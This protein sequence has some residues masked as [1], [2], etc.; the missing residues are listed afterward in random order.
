DI[1]RQSVY[2]YREPVFLP[3][4]STIH[5]RYTYDNSSQNVHN[6][7]NPPIRVRAGNRSVD[8]MGHLWMQ[9][10]PV[11]VP[12]NSPDPRLLLETAWMQNRLRKAPHDELALYNLGA[13]ETAEGQYS[14]ATLNYKQIVELDPKDA[15]AWNGLGVALENSG[16]WQSAQQ[17]F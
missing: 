15:R 5:M 11:H 13:A 12:P 2:R 17:A 6:P 10:L 4:G 8:E 14:A 16:D 7:N 3:K 9:V 1:D